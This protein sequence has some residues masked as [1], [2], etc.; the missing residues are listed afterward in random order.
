MVKKISERQTLK[1]WEG[2]ITYSQ[3][4]VW[5]SLHLIGRLH[6]ANAC[7]DTFPSEST[8]SAHFTLT[9]HISYFSHKQASWL[10]LS[11]ALG[12]QLLIPLTFLPSEAPQS[13]F[14][15]HHAGRWIVI[16]LWPSQFSFFYQ[17][18]LLPAFISYPLERLKS[19]I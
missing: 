13:W 17:N 11:P 16:Q 15:V 3:T 8:K 12:R 5:C 7:K 2:T 10:L 6:A 18:L 1:W 4:V 14:K 9:C 19:L